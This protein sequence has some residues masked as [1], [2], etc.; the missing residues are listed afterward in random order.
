MAARLSC[1]P[2]LYTIVMVPLRARGYLVKRHEEI[3]LICI[4]YI[5]HN[6]SST[7]VIHNADPV[8]IDQS[9]EYTP[10]FYA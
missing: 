4:A 6:A 5:P 2:S 8:P 1:R 3:P 9:V 10:L 7:E